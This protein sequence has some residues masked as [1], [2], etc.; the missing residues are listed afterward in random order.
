MCETY[1]LCSL[2]NF[3][4]TFQ[5]HKINVMD[6]KNHS[7]YKITVLQHHSQPLEQQP[8]SHFLATLLLLKQ[9]SQRIFTC[10][11]EI[12]LKSPVQAT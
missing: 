8:R 4:F 7:K 9:P 1:V 12:L 2:F 11:L 10:C 6:N 3:Q 5:R